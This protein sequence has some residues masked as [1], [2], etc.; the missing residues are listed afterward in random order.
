MPDGKASSAATQLRTCAASK[1]ASY[2]NKPWHAW[3]HNGSGASFRATRPSRRSERSPEIRRCRRR[4]PV[5]ARCTAAAGKSPP[6]P[7]WPVRCIPTKASIRPTAFRPWS[8]GI[9]NALARLDQIE[10]LEGRGRR[11]LVSADRRRR[12]SRLRRPAQR[13][14]VDEVDDHSRRCRRALRRPVELG[15]EVR[16]SRRQGVDSDAAGGAASR[17]RAAR[18]RCLEVPTILIA[19]TDANAARLVT[20]DVDPLDRDFLTGERTP[21]GF[22]VT[23]PGIEACIARSLAYAPHADLLWMET[24]EPSIEEARRFAEAI[25]ARYPGKLLAYNCSPSFN[26]KKKLDARFDRDVSRAARTRWATSS[27]SSRWPVST[28]STIVLR[29]GARLQGARD[30]GVR[31]VSSEEFASE[32]DGYTATR[33]QREVGTGYFDEV[34]NVIGEGKASTTALHGSTEAEQFY[35]DAALQHRLKAERMNVAPAGF[36]LNARSPGR[37]CR[38]LPSAAQAIHAAAAAAAPGAQGSARPR[39]R[40]TNSPIIFRRRRRRRATWRIELPGWCADQR[41]QMTGP[42]DDAELCVKMLNSGAPGVMLDLEDSMA[43]TWEHLMLGHRNIV[44][45][46]YGELTYDDAKRGERS[47]SRPARPCLEPRARPASLASRR[48]LAHGDE[49]VA[50]R[51]GVAGLSRRV[52]AAAAPALHLHSKIGVGRRSAVVDA[53][54]SMR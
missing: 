13:L 34:A 51:P 4:G 31:R 5:F 38:F 1:A 11:E 3:G 32:A 33:H 35:D 8:R 53:T 52:R 40:R 19:R 21:E 27:S 6:T 9:N 16:P 46:L 26:W 20:S 12:R 43:N 45:A 18:R 29:A 25:H 22:F 24:S 14:R 47:R 50:L 17:R 48:D 42:A 23:K 28:H 36:S 15:E 41:N 30:G 39:P 37:L 7:I 49:R 54:S 10:S 44:A 2:P